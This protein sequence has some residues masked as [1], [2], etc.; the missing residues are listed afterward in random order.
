MGEAANVLDYAGPL[1]DEQVE[2]YRRDGYLG[3]NG[4]LSDAEVAELKATTD[5]FIE[6]SRSVTA[7]DDVYDLEP[8]HTA[9]SPRLRRLSQPHLHHEAYRKMVSHE[10]LVS[11]VSQLIGDSVYLGGGSWA[12]K[13]N[14]KFAEFGSPVEWHQD[15]AFFPHTNDDLIAVGVAMDGMTIENGCLRVVPGTHLGPVLNHHQD[16]VFVGAVPPQGIEEQSVPILLRPGG[17]SLHHVRLLHGSAPNTSPRPRRLLLFEY[18]SGDAWPLTGSHSWES[19]ST[20][21]VRGQLT[22][23]ARLAAVP[24]RL[25]YPRDLTLGSIYDVQQAVRERGFQTA[26]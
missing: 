13:L 20:N 25:P 5:E 16:G 2:L 22:E 23:N 6:R 10:R 11:V 26:G 8:G 12:S 18:V 24:V 4:I 21:V 1:S 19:L 14:I 7:S 15:W 3:I 9:E 17:I